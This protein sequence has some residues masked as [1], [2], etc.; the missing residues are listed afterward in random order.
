MIGVRGSGGS[1][2]IT[3]ATATASDI[4]SGKVAYNNNG[5]IVGTHTESGTVITDATATAS[6]IVSGKVAYNNYGRIVGTHTCSS[7]G[8]TDGGGSGSIQTK[9]FYIPANSSITDNYNDII[10]WTKTYSC[11]SGRQSGPADDCGIKPQSYFTCNSIQSIDISSGNISLKNITDTMS[12]EAGTNFDSIDATG[13]TLD[14]D[15]NGGGIIEYPQ[16][17]VCTVAISKTTLYVEMGSG[18]GYGVTIKVYY[19]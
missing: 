7:G 4:V 18:Y 11:K 12:G 5:R 13:I 14:D 9:E 3:D 19:K 10:A 8:S 16:L 1:A 15:V 2:P 17:F 6:D